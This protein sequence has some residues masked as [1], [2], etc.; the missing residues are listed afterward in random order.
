MSS[1][2]SSTA[3]H[4][5]T[6]YDYFKHC[7]STSDDKLAEQ[8]KQRFLNHSFS[9]SG[10]IVEYDVLHQTVQVEMLALAASD[11]FF[12]FLRCHGSDFN[13]IRE[14]YPNSGVKINFIC[15]LKEDGFWAEPPGEPVGDASKLE[16]MTFSQYL[17]TFPNKWHVYHRDGSTFKPLI[18]E[19]RSLIYFNR[20]FKVPI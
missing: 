11:F 3:A 15:T 5:L 13:A 10:R 6:L 1:S 19:R 8:L 16:S 7:S 20:L 2:A 18:P 4:G 12:I 14:K 17:T 9:W